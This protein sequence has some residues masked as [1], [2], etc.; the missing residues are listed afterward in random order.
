MKSYQPVTGVRARNAHCQSCIV[1]LVIALSQFVDDAFAQ[2]QQKIATQPQIANP[3]AQ[4]VQLPSVVTLPQEQWN[5][6][7]IRVEQVKR[8]AFAKSI[9]LTGKISLNEDRVA[10][11]Y[12]MVEGTVDTVHVTLG[13]TV[14]ADDLLVVIHSRE[15][16]A[17]KLELY[18]ARMQLELRNTQNDLQQTIAANTN[19]LLSALRQGESIAEIEKRFRD[20]PMGDYR[21]RALA[22]FAAYL[23]SDADV[24]RLEGVAQTGAVSGKQLLAATTNR[25]ADLATFQA[26][27]EQIHY[28]LQTSTLMS[29]QAVKEAEAKVLVAATSLK[30]LSVSAEEIN[31]IDPAAQGERLSHYPLRSP[32][33]GTILTKDVVLREQVRPDVML[34]SIADLS[35]VWVTANIYEEH[36]PYLKSFKDRTLTLRNDALPDRTFNAKVFYT[37]EI[38]N[39]AT[40]TIS[41]RAI[42]DNSDRELKPG[43]FV[44]VELPILRDREPILVPISAVQDHEGKKFVFVYNG[45]DSFQRRDIK[46]GLAND[47]FLIVEDGL[48][49]GESIASGGG[50]IL[51]SRLLAELLGEE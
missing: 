21:E 31:K 36:L 24:Q 13:Q 44:T 16:G 25:N 23:K 49:E 41:L 17:A 20:R 12:S 1:L 14:K 45:K 8:Q 9:K 6:S 40:R 32:L 34:M 19:E 47:Q 42:A 22:S 38:M 18:Q 2:D 51:K 7:G 28:E 29:S 50:F 43:M 37:G 10:H 5:V 48:Q 15:V 33:S 35:T 11:V 30:I 26:R 3:Q 27:I 46:P 4:T 39:E